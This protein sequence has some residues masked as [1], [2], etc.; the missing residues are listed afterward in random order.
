MSLD[1]DGGNVTCDFHVDED[2][3]GVEVIFEYMPTTRSSTIDN[4]EEVE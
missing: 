2:K 1:P 3:D 4:G